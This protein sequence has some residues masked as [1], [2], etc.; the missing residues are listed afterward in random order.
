MKRANIAREAYVFPHIM[1][2]EQERLEAKE[3]DHICEVGQRVQTI[4]SNSNGDVLLTQ[5][6]RSGTISAKQLRDIVGQ[7]VTQPRQTI[8]LT[9][10]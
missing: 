1:N 3:V 5:V 2:V 10:S 4:V 6:V 7:M 9:G 8:R